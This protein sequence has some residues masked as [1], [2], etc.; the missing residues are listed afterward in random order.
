MAT[1]KKAAP[2]KSAGAKVPHVKAKSGRVVVR[3][4][5]GA[6]GRDNWRLIRPNQLIANEV[7]SGAENFDV[8]KLN[9]YLAAHLHPD[10]RKAF[11]DAAMADPSLDIEGLESMLEEMGTAVFADLSGG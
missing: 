7:M 6:F 3:A 8:A 10:D 4:T 1:A 5:Y 11:F 9:D 2:R